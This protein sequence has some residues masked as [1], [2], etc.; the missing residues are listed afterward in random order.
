[1]MRAN[2]EVMTEGYTMGRILKRTLKGFQDRPS[3]DFAKSLFFAQLGLRKSYRELYGEI[4]DAA[5]NNG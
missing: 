4:L 1:M 3:L 2:A 5:P